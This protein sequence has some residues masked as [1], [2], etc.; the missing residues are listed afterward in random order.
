M[1]QVAEIVIAGNYNTS[2]LLRRCEDLPVALASRAQV[3]GVPRVVAGPAKVVAENAGKAFI[4]EESGH[5]VA[6][7]TVSS[8]TRLAA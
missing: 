5:Q 2:E 8:S 3:K 4:D 7:R 6:A 1:E